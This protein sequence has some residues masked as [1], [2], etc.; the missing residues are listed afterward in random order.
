MNRH[1]ERERARERQR[2]SVCAG[3]KEGEQEM[4]KTAPGTAGTVDAHNTLAKDGLGYQNRL[5]DRQAAP[6]HPIVK[7]GS[8]VRRRA[9]R[10]MTPSERLGAVAR[11]ALVSH[12]EAVVVRVDQLRGRAGTVRV[13]PGR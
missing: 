4:A 7:V 6:A 9:A 5:A 10:V 11:V 13:M 12:P 8:A 1:R 2:E 3:V